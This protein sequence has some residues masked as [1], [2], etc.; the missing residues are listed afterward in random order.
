MHG[1]NTFV[2][3]MLVLRLRASLSATAASSPAEAASTI[4]R[5]R[6]LGRRRINAAVIGA[7]PTMVMSTGRPHNRRWR[8]T[9]QKLQSDNDDDG[10]RNIGARPVSSSQS[11]LLQSSSLSND[12][13]EPTRR[14]I[15]TP[16]VTTTTNTDQMYESRSEMGFDVHDG[17]VPTKKAALTDIHPRRSSSR[18]QQQRLDDDNDDES[19]TNTN[20][21][22]TED[23]L[24]HRHHHQK[25]YQQQDHRRDRKDYG[26]LMDPYYVPHQEGLTHL[27]QGG[28]PCDISSRHRQPYRLA[29]YGEESVYTLILLRHGERYDHHESGIIC[30]VSG[31]KCCVYSIIQ[32]HTLLFV[33]SLA[34][35]FDCVILAHSRSI[36][37]YHHFTFPPVNGMH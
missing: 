36:I 6:G 9:V 23:S 1:N 14:T 3:T 17:T 29:E 21:E 33:W 20:D 32:Y 15:L 24:N 22:E 34:C 26:S 28:T 35:L 18:R 37:S 31:R 5:L 25:I 30:H 10:N 27:I 16:P 12:V 19:V 2:P 11:L 7:A 13:I 4:L 8:S